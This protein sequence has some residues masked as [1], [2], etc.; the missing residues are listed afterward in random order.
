MPRYP[1]ETLYDNLGIC[2]DKSYLGAAIFRQMGYETSLLRF[3]QDKHLS[4]GIG[5]PDGYQELGT[6][7]AIME[8]TGKGF[9]VGDI[10]NLVNTG[11]AQNTIGNIPEISDN[12]IANTQ[13]RKIS[14]ASGVENVSTGKK[15]TRIVERTTLRSQIENLQNQLS[16]EKAKVEAAKNLATQKEGEL[17]IAENS[18][19]ANPSPGSYNQYLKVYNSYKSAITAN[20]QVYNYNQLVKKYNSLVDEYKNY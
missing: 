16:D 18:Y 13:D 8:L 2:T 15:Y 7:Y 4:I 17:Q 3:D 19:T 11:L 6:S 9:L 14:N 10:P 5:V 20:N 1:Y 12:P